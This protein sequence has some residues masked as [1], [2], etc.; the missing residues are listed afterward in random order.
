MSSPLNQARVRAFR[1]IASLPRPRLMIV[2]KIATRV[3]RIPFV[4]LVVTVLAAG[5][6]GLL[7]LNTALQSGAYQVTDLR[8]TSSS[9]SIEQQNLRTKVAD[10]QQPQRLADKAQRLG[11]VQSDSPVFLSLSTGAIIGKAVPAVAT[12]RPDVGRTVSASPV[13]VGKVV[14]LI[15]GQ[16]ASGYTAAERHR[17]EAAREKTSTSDDTAPSTGGTR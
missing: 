11:M 10:L 5:L 2:P 3:P 13:R 8:Q 16:H 12:N 17:G 1:P 6:I 14:A 9:L 15:S 7:L 4:L